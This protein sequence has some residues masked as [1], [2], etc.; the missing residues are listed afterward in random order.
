[1][2]LTQDKKS[3][4]DLR[5]ALAG[6]RDEIG[7]MGEAST[8]AQESF[9]RQA[10]GIKDE[11]HE[12]IKAKTQ[13]MV[14]SIGG[15]QKTVNDVAQQSV[16]NFDV[17]GLMLSQNII[18]GLHSKIET[19]VGFID[20]TQA[21]SDKRLENLSGVL[22]EAIGYIEKVEQV[23]KDTSAIDAL[24]RAFGDAQGA[25]GEVRALVVKDAKQSADS[26]AK[27][28]IKI[29]DLAQRLD[30]VAGQVRD[31]KDTK[32]QI[33]HVKDADS[34]FALQN[35]G[36][37]TPDAGGYEKGNIVR[38]AAA[39]WLC[40]RDTTENPTDTA[41]DWAL[42]ARD[43]RGGG[44]PVTSGP[45]TTT[46]TWTDYVTRGIYVSTSGQVL[47]YTFNGASVYRFVPDPYVHAQDQFFG[48]VALTQ[49]LASRA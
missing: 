3:I 45:V 8:A 19:V 44:S 43:G 1:M 20:Q 5:D 41:N 32:P 37:W 46:L 47:T 34:S 21:V 27:A 28:G 2:I 25:I 6:V 40:V 49:L 24:K 22:S 31:I 7:M 12:L 18:A 17:I 35:R 29:K 4:N 15:V 42:L 33:V 30:A 16:F 39:S 13:G 10:A 9:K 23:A 26:S 38:H 48:D 14:D 11:A 36:V